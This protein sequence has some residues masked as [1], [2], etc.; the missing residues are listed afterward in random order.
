MGTIQTRPL[1]PKSDSPIL[2]AGK[3]SLWSYSCPEYVQGRW[4]PGVL[5][6]ILD[7]LWPEGFSGRRASCLGVSGLPGDV[8]VGAASGGGPA[9]QI[10]ECLPHFLGRG[11]TPGPI[12]LA[13]SESSL[14]LHHPF[15]P[16]HQKALRLRTGGQ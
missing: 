14:C 7:E 13:S 8:V 5:T 3:G 6:L 1:I 15:D 10:P 2:L 9:G 11:S 12:L 16:S 4:P